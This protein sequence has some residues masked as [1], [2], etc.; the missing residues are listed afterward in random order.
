MVQKNIHRI[1]SALLIILFLAACAAPALPSP[2][3]THTTNT[4][5]PPTISTEVA[6]E[7]ITREPAEGLC[8]NTFYTVREGSSWTY[9]STGGPAGEYSFTDTITSAR[10]DGFTLS[11]QI[12]SLTRTQ[13]WTCRPEGLVALQLGRAPAAMLN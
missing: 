7:P 10:P 12:G 11:T 3:Q 9:K 8:T 2:P 6:T 4:Q 13:E 5:V 1:V